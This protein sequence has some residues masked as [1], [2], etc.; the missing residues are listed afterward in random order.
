VLTFCWCMLSATLSPVSS[1]NSKRPSMLTMRCPSMQCVQSS[2]RELTVSW[3]NSL[4][5]RTLDFIVFMC[6][7]FTT[8]KQIP[9]YIK[10]KTNFN[11]NSSC[12]CGTLNKWDKCKITDAI[13]MTR[14]VYRQNT[15]V[16]NVYDQL[17][18]LFKL[19]IVSYIYNSISAKD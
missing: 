1:V 9:N 18:Q 14:H 2:S 8:T 19:V 7:I 13:Q 17:S 12:Y 16:C 3:K 11:T 5:D 6:S 15:Y 4:A 10:G